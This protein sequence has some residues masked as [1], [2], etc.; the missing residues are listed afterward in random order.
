MDKATVE[1][2]KKI[3]QIKENISNELNMIKKERDNF[4][5]DYES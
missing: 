2:E 4:K 5:L 3:A 1:N